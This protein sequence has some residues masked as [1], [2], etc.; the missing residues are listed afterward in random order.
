M[1]NKKESLVNCPLVIL[2]EDTLMVGAFLY[3][4]VYWPVMGGWCASSG[5]GAGAGSSLKRDLH[6]L[7]TFKEGC[8]C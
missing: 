4:C 8:Y 5:V 3:N 6:L 1:T 2:V 7:T